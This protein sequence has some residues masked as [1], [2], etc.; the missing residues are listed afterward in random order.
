MIPFLQIS[1]LIQINRLFLIREL[2]IDLEKSLKE[3]LD[4]VNNQYIIKELDTG[5]P[6]LIL[7]PELAKGVTVICD[8]D[9]SDFNYGVSGITDNVIKDVKGINNHKKATVKVKKLVSN[10]SDK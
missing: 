6:N 8:A 2:T 1:I 4:K 9:D 7:D 3:K 10:T 5:N